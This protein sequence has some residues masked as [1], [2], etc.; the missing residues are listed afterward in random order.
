MQELDALRVE[1]C[2]EREFF[3]DNVPVRNHHIN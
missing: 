3:I 1:V 2:R